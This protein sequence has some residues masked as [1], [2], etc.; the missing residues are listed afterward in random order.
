MKTYV[1]DLDGTLCTRVSDG[2]YENSRPV[3]ERINKVN[4][5]FEEGNKIIVCTARGMGRH[6]NDLRRA[7][8]EFYELTINQLSLWGLKHH[9]LHLGKPSGD[10]YIDDK[11]IKDEDFFNTRN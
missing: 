10:V 3:V 5:L 6:N 7:Y 4:S 11:G 9:E 1:F 8:D 2:N